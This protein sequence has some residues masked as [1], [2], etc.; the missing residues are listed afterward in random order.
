MVFDESMSA[1]VPR[2]TKSGGLSYILY[3]KRKS[4]T[5]GTKF[6]CVVDGLTCKL[7]WLEI[8]QG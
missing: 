1:F 8:Q 3:V 7:L 2:T 4:E 5:L 6:K